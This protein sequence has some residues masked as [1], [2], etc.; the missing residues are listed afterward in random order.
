M[1]LHA[2]QLNTSVD[3][4]ITEDDKTLLQLLEHIGAKES[5][6]KSRVKRFY[7]KFLVAEI[8]RSLLKINEIILPSTTIAIT[9]LES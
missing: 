1:P 6:C 4:S 2:K 3:I 8:A 5:V 7:Y 9:N